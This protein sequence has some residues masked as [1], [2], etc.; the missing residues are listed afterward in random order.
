MIVHLKLQDDSEEYVDVVRMGVHDYV[1]DAF[2][3]DLPEV[4]DSWYVSRKHV[5]ILMWIV[6]KTWGLFYNCQD[7]FVGCRSRGSWRVEIWQFPHAVVE[8][9]WIWLIM[10]F[11]RAQLDIAK[12]WTWQVLVVE[13]V[14]THLRTKLLLESNL[15]TTSCPE[16]SNEKRFKL[17]HHANPI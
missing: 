3:L 17:I 7:L 14:H 10:L 9:Q 2:L 5:V 16:I 1:E 8:K 6:F 12:I 15:G 11:S 13:W 4:K